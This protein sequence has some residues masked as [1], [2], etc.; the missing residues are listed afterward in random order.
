MKYKYI[1]LGLLMSIWGCRGVVKEDRDLKPRDLHK[2]TASG[3]QPVFRG[4][5][6]RNIL[7]PVGGI[8]TGDILL[9]GRGN[10]REIEFFG[11]ADLDEVPPYM[12]FFAAWMKPAPE[13][14][15]A[16]EVEFEP[17]TRII[18]AE[19]ENDFPNPFGVPRNQL[20]GVP[21][22]KQ[23]SFQAEVPFARLLL[24]DEKVPAVFELEAFNPLIPLDV[25]N[26]SLPACILHWTVTNTLERGLDVSILFSLSNP[27]MR[28]VPGSRPTNR[29]ALTYYADSDTFPSLVF[30]SAID[31][32][33]RPGYGEMSVTTLKEGLDAVTFF[34]HQGWWDDAHRLWSDFTEDGRLVPQT[35]PH[36]NPNRQ[37]SVSA[38][39]LHK[40]LEPGEKWTVPFIISWYIPLREPEENL[41]F[42]NPQPDKKILENYYARDY[43]SAMDVTRYILGNRKELSEKSEHFREAL[44][45]SSFP[46]YV[47]DALGANIVPL[48]SNLLLRDGQGTV[49]GY[50]G[51]GNDFGCCPGNCT[52]V[53]N[54]A[55][56]MA[57]LFPSL[58]RNVRERTFLHDTH[59]NGYQ[60]FRTVMTDDDWWFTN[61]AADG[62]MG[63]IMRVYRE[64]KRSGD[65]AWLRKLWP[66][67]KLALEFAWKGTGTDPP[68]DWMNHAKFPWDPEKKGVLSGD[69]HNTYDI[70]FFGPNMM[71]GSLYLGAL[72]SCSE[73]ASVMNEKGKADEYR[74]LYQKGKKYYEEELWN[75]EYFIQKIRVNEGLEIPERLV[76]P[77]NPGLPRYQYGEGCLSDQLL[78]QFL[79]YVNGM[80]YL[81]DQEK[82]KK[83]LHSIYRYNYRPDFREVENVQ[84]VYAL[85][86]EAG[87]QVCTW[88]PGRKPLF[89]FVYTGEVWT[90]I[91]Y[92]VAASLIWAGMVDE[93]LEL[94]RAVR[95]RYRGVNRNPFAEIES[96]RYYAR[97]MS[98]W[99]LLLALSGVYYDGY[100]N[101]M[102]FD[103]AIHQKD[104]SSFWSAGNAWGTIQIE[105]NEIVLSVKHGILELEQFGLGAR[106][107]AEYLDVSGK[108]I[109][110][111]TR[112]KISWII[113]SDKIILNEGEQLSMKYQ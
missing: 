102:A 75:G 92:Q 13:L 105:Q 106:Y 1:L 64:W 9:G 28:P 95:E 37:H 96:G 84:R 17:I 18:E 20:A 87:L 103:P 74:A 109:A 90:G 108:S 8:G 6:L 45:G 59:E 41:H 67:V 25:K 10:I 36:V 23:G 34:P 43:R 26:S 11:R 53:W 40:R 60:C 47:L 65:T 3:K 22:F 69:Q 83:A 57:F 63:S 91:E 100:L 4:D 99:A 111:H 33:A 31:D 68:Y 89:P 110:V 79:A 55:Q 7:F 51:L 32:P 35:G 52:H 2:Y 113:L 27:F 56:T 98:S 73:M 71:T 15:T 62:Q 14:N 24:Q 72:K 30:R 12:T 61:V 44:Y 76:S 107:N 78:G 77:S 50:E 42:G 82:T 58:E 81:V 88:P 97:A 104:F 29:G 86:A 93:G 80:G 49:H 39:C 5:S 66:R 94:V 85:N 70:N 21:R 54:Y 101:A 38:L 19:H 48:K 16:V 46:D 112:D